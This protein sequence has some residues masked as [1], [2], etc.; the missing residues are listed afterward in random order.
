[1]AAN[2]IDP[3]PASA[4]NL[5]LGMTDLEEAFRGPQGAAK[6]AEL[7]SRIESLRAEIQSG[8][9]R[10]LPQ[11]DYER[12]QV[13]LQSLAAARDIVLKFPKS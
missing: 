9:D 7:L 2:Q 10:G 5:P 1:M 12:S 13:V 6:G 4:A 3:F 11:E 8:I